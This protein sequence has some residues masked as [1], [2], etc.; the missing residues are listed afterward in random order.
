M[1]FVIVRVPPKKP[2][3]LLSVFTDSAKPEAIRTRHNSRPV[4]SVLGWVCLHWQD[5]SR[6][7]YHVDGDTGPGGPTSSSATG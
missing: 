5:I 4:F 2:F 7:S 1:G 6:A 3:I